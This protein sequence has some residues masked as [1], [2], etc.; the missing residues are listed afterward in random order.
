ML[1]ELHIRQFALIEQLSVELGPGFTAITGETGAGKSI[2]ID[3]LSAAVGDRVASDVVRTGAEQAVVEAVFDASMAPKAL[4]I[5]SEVGVEVDA[6][7]TLILTRVISL[8]GRHRCRVNGRPVPLTVLRQIGDRLVDIHGQHEHQALIREENHLEFLD[9]YGGADIQEHRTQ[10]Q[11]VFRELLLARSTREKLTAAARDRAREADLLRFQAEEIRAA[12]LYAGEEEELAALRNR[13]ANVE[14]LREG[15]AYAH[16]LLT[17]ATEE[18]LGAVDLARESL[19]RLAELTGLDQGL[20]ELAA[21][22]ETTVY[23]LEDVTTR[24]SDY[25]HS[26]EAEPETL[27]QVERRLALISRLKRKYGDTVADVIRFGEEAEQRLVELEG[28]EDRLTELSEEVGKLEMEAGLIAAKLSE[29]RQEAAKRLGQALTEALAD[30]G[31]QQARFEVGL[32]RT[33]TPDGLPDGN[34]GRWLADERGIDQCRFLFSANPGEPLKPLSAIASG[35]ELSRLMLLMKSICSRSHEIPTVVF[36]EID[37]GIGGQASHA[38]GRKLAELSQ[39]TQVLCVTHLPQIARVADCHFHVAKTMH[40]GR[41]Q[42]TLEL[43]DAERRIGE[44]ARMM[45]ARDGD[46][47]AFEHAAELLTDATTTRREKAAQG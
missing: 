23:Q 5:A 12:G 33:T 3:A 19:R 25:L 6:D 43:L 10:Y 40:K 38:V 2:V 46:R 21:L 44:L 8:S 4:A 20:E 39:R 17:G 41:M 31:M 15:L 47:A 18:R 34:G 29:L 9:A 35:G 7:G 24:I 36:D 27:D 42:V 26:V 13:L 14:R 45:G 30:V 32:S 16:A 37:A 22:L 1:T 28:A 11:Q